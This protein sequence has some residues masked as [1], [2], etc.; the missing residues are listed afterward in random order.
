MVPVE[1]VDEAEVEGKSR[2]PIKLATN[3]PQSKVKSLPL[4][5]RHDMC[6]RVA[7]VVRNLS[8]ICS[9]DS[10]Y[11]ALIRTLFAKGGMAE[12]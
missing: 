10:Y 11:I 9:Q 12:Q 1:A 7:H 8:T 5:F 3:Y 6:D 4:A 2:F